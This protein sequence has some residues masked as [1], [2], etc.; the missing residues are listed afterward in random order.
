MPYLAMIHVWLVEL[1]GRGSA[2]GAHMSPLAR[3][4][5]SQTTTLA[6]ILAGF[7]HPT[8]P[9]NLSRQAVWRNGSPLLAQGFVIANSTTDMSAAGTACSG[10]VAVMHDPSGLQMPHFECSMVLPALNRCEKPVH[11]ATRKGQPP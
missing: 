8:A 3:D 5:K 2:V 1:R 6:G 4:L 9:S 7:E 10:I 11:I